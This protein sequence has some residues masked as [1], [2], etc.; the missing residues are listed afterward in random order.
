MPPPPSSTRRRDATPRPEAKWETS[1]FGC[2]RTKDAGCNCCVQHVCCGPCV[3]G[4]ALRAAGISDSTLFATLLC[5][6]GDT[7]LDETAGY[8]ARR[9]LAKH[10]GIVEDDTTS[11]LIAC[12]CAPLARV[13]EVDT[14]LVREGL[15]Y[16]CAGV[17]PG[18][19]VQARME[20]G[21][22]GV[23]V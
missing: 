3:W 22:G 10:Y 14:I 6:G 1:L 18:P 8:L 12:C 17:K 20:R 16:G 23:R 4:S 13:Q 2:F 19:V 21:R 7:I 15:V 11:L 9:R 5:C